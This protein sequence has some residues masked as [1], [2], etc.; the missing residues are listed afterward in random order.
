M[1][2]TLLKG[3]LVVAFLV[4]VLVV[5]I[6]AGRQISMLVDLAKTVF[7]KSLPATPLAYDGSESAGTFQIGDLELRTEGIDYKPYPMRISWDS[8]QRPVLSVSGKSF[9]LSTEPGDETSFTVERSL[10]SWPTP[11]DFNF[12]TGVSPSWRR[13]LY[14]V[15]RWKKSSG[16]S[17]KMVWRYEQ[18]FYSS[19]GWTSGF[20]TRAGSTGLIEAQVLE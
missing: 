5:W 14:Y 7:L 1:R 3:L 16:A 15:L 2:R 4:V 20:M 17:L 9:L 19:G 18:Y 11:F 13:H 8:Q 10:M 12:M 6:L